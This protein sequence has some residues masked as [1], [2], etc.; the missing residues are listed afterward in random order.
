MDILGLSEDAC[1][2]LLQDLRERAPVGSDYRHAHDQSFGNH[3][4]EWLL[5]QAGNRNQIAIRIKPDRVHFADKA[6]VGVA[7]LCSQAIKIA[8][9]ARPGDSEL[10]TR[11]VG[12]TKGLDELQ[13]AF[14]GDNAAKETDDESVVRPPGAACSRK[15]H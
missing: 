12:S 7:G 8:C 1:R 2:K 6:D 11:Y 3:T 5:P 4:T 14:R 9:F 10:A 15:I 13:D